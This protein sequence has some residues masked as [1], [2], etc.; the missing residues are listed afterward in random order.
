MGSGRLLVWSW[1]LL[2]VQK[3]RLLG[4]LGELPGLFESS[5][6]VFFFLGEFCDSSTSAFTVSGLGLGRSVTPLPLPLRF[7]V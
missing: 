3:W 5:R 4:S 7:R 2:G 1:W 6:E